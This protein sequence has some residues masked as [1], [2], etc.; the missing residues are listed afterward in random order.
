MSA[1]AMHRRVRAR[2]PEAAASVIV[3]FG[4]VIGVARRAVPLVPGVTGACLMS[5]GTAM[6]YRPAGV[7]L[8]GVFLLVLDWRQGPR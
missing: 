1:V 8:G 3:G 6:I 7:I 4:R 5:W 2:W